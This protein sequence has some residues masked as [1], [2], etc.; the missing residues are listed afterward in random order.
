MSKNKEVST[1]SLGERV[2]QA[3]VAVAAAKETLMSAMVQ[4]SLIAKEVHDTS[5][6]GPYRIEGQLY[7]IRKRV[8]KDEDGRPVSGGREL[9]YFVLVGGSEIKEL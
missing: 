5:G 8:E 7:T 1:L 2:R 9:Y 6:K 4:R 3:N